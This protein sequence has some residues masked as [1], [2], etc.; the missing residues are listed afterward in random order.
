M[1]VGEKVSVLWKG[2]LLGCVD[3]GCD[4]C[5]RTS[6]S[7]CDKVCESVCDMVC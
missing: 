3:R 2:V 7:M 4:K 6:V 5:V 1:K